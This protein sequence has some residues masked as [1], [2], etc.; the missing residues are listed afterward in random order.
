MVT[1]LINQHCNLRMMCL[2]LPLTKDYFLFH[3]FGEAS[4]EALKWRVQQTHKQ[5]LNEQSQRGARCFCSIGWL[6]GG[7]VGEESA[8]IRRMWG[9]LM[10][11]HLFLALHPRHPGSTIYLA[12]V[13][14]LLSAVLCVLSYIT[15][16]SKCMLSPY[17]QMYLCMWAGLVCCSRTSKADF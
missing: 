2:A 10:L 7:W 8:G 9:V 17:I 16:A 1:L 5:A 13:K 11:S 12:A 14:P 3:F 6:L 4:D 15:S